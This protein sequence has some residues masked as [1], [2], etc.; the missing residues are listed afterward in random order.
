MRACLWIVTGLVASGAAACGGDG[1]GQSCGT[2][3]DCE[4]GMVC[5]G[6]A[7]SPCSAR[8]QCQAEYGAAATCVSGRCGVPACE[9][10][11]PGCPCAAG[12]TCTDS[13]CMSGTCVACVRGSVGC[14]CFDNGSCNKGARCSGDECEECPVGGEGC[15]CSDGE[16]D[17]P[18]ECQGDVCTLPPCPAG[19]KAC[20]CRDDGGEACDGDL[21]CMQDGKCAECRNDVVGCG[22]LDGDCQDD[23]V[24]GDDDLCRE[25][26]TCEAAACVEHQLCEVKAGYDAV[27]LEQ[28]ETG[29]VWTSGLCLSPL[30]TCD[31]DSPDS[32]LADCVKA[33][34]VCLTIDGAARCGECAAGWDAR[35]SGGACEKTLSCEEARCDAANRQCVGIKPFMQCGD[36]QVG[37]YP[38]PSNRAGACKPPVTCFDLTCESGTFC[39]VQGVGNPNA[40]C[41]ASVCAAGEA[42][43]EN[44]G[45]CVTC[46]T[47]A[48][49]DDAGETG[50]HWMVT[51][52]GSDTCICETRPD[53]YW[54]H[55]LIRPM[56]CD[57][58]GDGWVRKPAWVAMSSA[59][60]AIAANAR[61]HLR[62]IDRFVLQNELDQQLSV[63]LC[64]A[65][66]YCAVYDGVKSP[67]CEGESVPVPLYE[68]E[69]N[70]D[71]DQIAAAK[72]TDAPVYGRAGSDGPVVGRA[73]RPEE[74]SPLTKACVTAN[75]DLNDN[76]TPDV[77]DWQ[78]SGAGEGAE[79]VFSDFSYFVELYSGR[80]VAANTP[81]FG[82]WLIV[83]RSRKPASDFLLSYGAGADEYWRSCTRGR[84]SEADD[85]GGTPP[86]G[87]DFAR[88]FCPESAARCVPP[89]PPTEDKPVGGTIPSHGL[90]VVDLPRSE[91]ECRTDP[92]PGP[93]SC[94]DKVV[95]RGMAHHSQFRCVKILDDAD[96]A[97]AI[98]PPGGGGYDFNRCHVAC[99]DHD[100][101]CRQDCAGDRCILSSK[102]PPG[103]AS[104]SLFDPVL[105]C[106]VVVAGKD[107][108]GF[109]L[110][111]YAPSATYQRG[112]I[113]EWRPD[114]DPSGP[115]VA[116]WRSL[117]PWWSVGER[118]GVK[119]VGNPDAFGAMQCGCSKEYG[120][121]MCEIG[122][123]DGH[124]SEPYAEMPRS[125]YWMCGE[126]SSTAYS[127]N[128]DEFGPAFAKVF[129]R[130]QWVLRGGVPSGLPTDGAMLCEDGTNC[131]TG[132]VLRSR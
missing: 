119:G 73:L 104:A 19:G 92:V 105:A 75:A 15:P 24:C 114:S 16:C 101:D 91:S 20:P 48:C 94:L 128:V 87:M 130:E 108:V 132:Y 86:A 37:F 131:Q 18:L 127:E 93:W 6:G 32:I 82:S 9:D 120:G 83:E 55:P 26:V 13:H 107:D 72:G 42:Y 58:D 40:T 28:C 96:T 63:F 112:C 125:G 43:S 116:A 77:E 115:A 122:C 100:L 12:E 98:A 8:V 70:D 99:P 44:S 31:P 21:H 85:P 60:P 22:C 3:A 78:G 41:Q 113:D 90:H 11:S 7:C 79:E 118:S 126:T 106:D 76:G 50:R 25:P 33:N 129:G 123:P 67:C 69:R 5:A 29:L 51:K 53:F 2:A 62:K 80:F 10:G 57:R 66:G 102:P 54:D 56:P 36:C 117:C 110:V 30:A 35:T 4:D 45:R 64:G 71:A 111:K 95:W 14:I 17:A 65:E 23:L 68:S 103:D 46:D 49:G 39:V 88:W 59:D 97:P 124:V 61:C 89:P 38:D 1:S 109:A 81:L 34:R 121:S 52:A 84:D 27:C 74:L 47:P